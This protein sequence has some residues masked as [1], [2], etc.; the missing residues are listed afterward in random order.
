M[1]YH[2]LAS[3]TPTPV[4]L[5]AET[6]IGVLTPPFNINN[7][8]YGQ[9]IH[10]AT[11]C[12]VTAGAT[13]TALTLRLYRGGGTVGSAPSGLTAIGPASPAHTIAAGNTA[14]LALDAVDTGVSLA[15]SVQYTVTAQQ[16]AGTG[17]GT[18]N[19]MFIG[20]EDATAF[21]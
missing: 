1:V 11:T 15:S 19:Y 21:E 13:T 12:N 8:S 17:N 3:T 4:T 16:T 14:Q 20:A 7:P 5:A 18:C 6:V 9:G 10:I 2:C